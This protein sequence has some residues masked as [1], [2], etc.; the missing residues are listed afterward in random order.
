MCGRPRAEPYSVIMDWAPGGTILVAWYLIGL[1][2]FGAAALWRNLGPVTR[3]RLL[4]LGLMLWQGLA[5]AR[6]L[7]LG[8]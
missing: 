3:I 6:A 7:G 2:L 8:S 5:F 4:A 1:G